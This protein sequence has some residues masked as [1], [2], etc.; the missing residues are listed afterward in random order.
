MPFLVLKGNLNAKKGN[1]GLLWV[2][3]IWSKIWDSGSALR[4]LG[5]GFKGLGLLELRARVELV[6]LFA[7]SPIPRN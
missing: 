5:F 4:L 6:A 1:K 2:L 7:E 3:V